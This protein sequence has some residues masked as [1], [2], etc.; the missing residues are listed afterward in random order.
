MSIFNTYD[1]I[2]VGGGHAGSEAASASANLGAKTLLITMN[3]QNIA[4][5]SCN[6][7]MGGIAKGQIVREIDALGGFSGII[8]DKTAIQFKMLNKSKGPAMWSPRAQSDR[9]RFAEAWRWQ[10]E[11]IDGLDLYQDSV[12][13]LLF[14]KDKVVAILA[15]KETADKLKKW[16]S[17][18]NR[19]TGNSHPYDRE[20]WFDFIKTAVDTDSSLTV[21]DLEQWLTEEKNWFV[22]EENSITEGIVLDFEYGIDLLKYYVGKGN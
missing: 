19:S 20:R 10:L 8:T 14:N 9:M 22:D 3:L 7:A 16:E 11:N 6:P 2:V 13:G 5:M 18:C 1:V 17:L 4:Q 21:G 15:N 12:N